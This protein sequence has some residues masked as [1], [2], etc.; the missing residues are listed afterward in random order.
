MEDEDVTEGPLKYAEKLSASDRP[1][2]VND[3]GTTKRRWLVGQRRLCLTKRGRLRELFLGTSAYAAS[4]GSARAE[5]HE[6]AKETK[7][8]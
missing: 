1:P 5:G 2:M 4:Q 7:D 6:Q 3:L 8:H